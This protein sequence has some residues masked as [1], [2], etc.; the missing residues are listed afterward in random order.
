M[1]LLSNAAESVPGDGKVKIVTD[2]RY[3]DRPIRGYEDVLE[4]DYVLPSILD[5][6]I[7]I[8]A[9]DLSRIIEPFFTK[10]VMGYTV[11][12]VSSGEAAVAYLK[13]GSADL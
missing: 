11:N 10:K 7:G 3:L 9:E 4:G 5:S 13:T 6:G 8:A 2:N 1:N 12:T